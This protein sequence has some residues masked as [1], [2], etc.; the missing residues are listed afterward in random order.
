MND[1]T[2]KAVITWDQIK[3]DSV[4]LSRKLRSDFE[5]PDKILAITRGGLIPASLVMSFND[6]RPSP[7]DP[8]PAGL[9][10]FSP[11]GSTTANI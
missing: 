8:D 2:Q 3:E 10:F 5:V 9:T 6:L 7:L 1:Y 4:A 11:L